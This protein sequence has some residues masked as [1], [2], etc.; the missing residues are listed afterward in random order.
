M[1]IDLKITNNTYYFQGVR[2]DPVYGDYDF[3][4]ELITATSIEEA[5]RKLDEKTIL[6]SWKTVCIIEINNTRHYESV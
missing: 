1:N 4:D 2:F 5:W 6:K 3:A